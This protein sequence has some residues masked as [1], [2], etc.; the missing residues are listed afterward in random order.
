MLFIAYKNIFI[1]NVIIII[2]IIID[3]FNHVRI[4]RLLRIFILE[5][6]LLFSIDETPLNNIAT[7]YT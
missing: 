7:L 3:T 6:V 4:F 5:F 2:K 1:I